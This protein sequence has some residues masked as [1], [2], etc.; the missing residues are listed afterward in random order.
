MHYQ[1]NT[2]MELFLF[3]VSQ[4]DEMKKHTDL[5][6]SIVYLFCIF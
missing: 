4:C 6:R 5:F 2:E 3:V 1:N